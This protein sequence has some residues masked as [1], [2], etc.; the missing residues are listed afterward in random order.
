MTCTGNKLARRGFLTVGALGGFGLTLGDLLRI[1]ARADQK[2]YDFIAPKADSVIHIYL[3]GGI[4][5]QESFDP[6]PIV[7]SNIAVRWE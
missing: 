6:S 1:E 5:H 4:A 3:P 2:H 7:P